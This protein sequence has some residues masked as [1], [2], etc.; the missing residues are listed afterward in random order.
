MT[1]LLPETLTKSAKTITLSKGKH[2]FLKGEEPENLF[3]LV[4]GNIRLSRCSESGQDCTLQQIQQGF[5]AEASLFSQQGYHCDAFAKETSELLAIPLTHFRHC[6][7]DADFNRYW[8][9]TLSSEIRR[10]RN[11]VERLSLN[12]AEARVKHYLQS[13]GDPPKQKKQWAKLLGLSHEAL[14]RCLARMEKQTEAT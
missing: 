3:Y 6:L 1:V 11:Q 4:S 14:Y 9:M 10:L 8:M 5:L 13:E 12:T 7:Q 2:L